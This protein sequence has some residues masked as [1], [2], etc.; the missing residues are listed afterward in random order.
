MF[1]GPQEG[2]VKR[3]RRIKPDERVPVAFTARERQLIMDHTFAGPEVIEPLE[4]ARP[5][6]GRYRLR[7][8]LDDLDDLL[9]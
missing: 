3:A 6:G 4:Q 5:R 1:Y 7:L 8:T 2:R 9:G